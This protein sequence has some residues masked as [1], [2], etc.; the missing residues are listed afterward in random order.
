MS[1]PLQSKFHS[2]W[3]LNDLSK[4]GLIYEDRSITWSSLVS[5]Y[6]RCGNVV[7]AFDLFRRMRLERQKP[8]QLTLGSILR[9]CSALGLIQ[10]G[11]QIHGYVV[12]TGFE[13]NVFVVTVLVDMYAKCKCISEAE[14]LFKILSIKDN[15]I[16]WTAMV[17]GYTQNACKRYE[18]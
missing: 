8:S 3:V 5:G 13:S 6:C 18:D 14:Y 4:S 9:V 7:E 2:N 16:L 12:K 17:T 11:E 1:I 15:H 10:S